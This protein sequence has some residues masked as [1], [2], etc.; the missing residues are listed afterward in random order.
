MTQ[1]ELAVRAGVTQSHVAA[2][3]KG[4]INPR[5]STIKRLFAAMSCDLAFQPAPRKS[6]SEFLRGRA[7]SVALKRLK[8][9]TGTMSLEDQAPDA[10]MFRAL[11]E[12]R[13]DE[14]LAD[15]SEKLWSEDE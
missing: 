4:K 7:R 3:E 6:L 9:S 10:E 1:K 8:Q 15:P 12:K 14:V 2:I 11:L 13:T 5:L